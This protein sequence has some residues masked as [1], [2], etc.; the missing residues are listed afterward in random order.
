[1]PALNLPPVD[2]ASVTLE[3]QEEALA[4]IF[5]FARAIGQIL[6]ATPSDDM[7]PVHRIAL[8]IEEQVE[9]AEGMRQ[10]AVGAMM[11]ITE[12]QEGDDD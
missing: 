7:R 11:E 4:A 6:G 8:A 10:Q 12:E 1:M 9:L 5:D 3:D 2:Y